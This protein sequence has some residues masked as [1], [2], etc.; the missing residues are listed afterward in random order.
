MDPA[1]WVME[2]WDNVGYGFLCHGYSESPS[3]YPTSAVGFITLSSSYIV[4]LSLETHK[5]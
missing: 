2:K 4:P 5:K 3:C 1:H